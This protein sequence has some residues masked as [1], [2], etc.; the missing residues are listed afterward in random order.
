MGMYNEVYKK[1]PSCGKRGILQISQIVLGFGCFDLDDPQSIVEDLRSTCSSNQRVKELLGLLKKRIEN[2]LRNYEAFECE[3]GNR[4]DLTEEEDK[5]NELIDI[6]R[7][8][9]Q[10]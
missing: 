10:H 9:G 1:C 2:A 8:I 7:S 4:F 3:C 5:Q 6:V